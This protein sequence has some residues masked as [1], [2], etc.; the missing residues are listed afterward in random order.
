Y[1]RFSVLNLMKRFTEQRNL[2]RSAKT[3]FAT[4]F[5]TLSSLH[6]QRDN[7]KKV[8]A[9]WQLRSSKWEK[10]QL[11]KKETQ[12]VLMSSFWN[13]IVYA[14][15][16]TDLLFVHFVW[17][18]VR[19]PAMGY[20][21]EA[22][23]RAKAAIATSFQGKVDKYEEIYE[24]INIRWA[25]QL[26]G[27]LHAAGNFLNPEYYCDDC[28]I[29]Q[30]RGDV[31]HEQCIQRLATNIEKQDKITKELTVYKTDEGLCGM[32]VAIRHRKTKAPVEW[33]SYGSSNPNLQQFSIKILSLTCSSSR[34]E[35]NW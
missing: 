14:L 1:H 31:F 27:L 23:D 34:C 35:R 15:K 8:F 7:L 17:L 5:I 4:S 10:D 18:M 20:I 26:H 28:T 16:V 19:N 22:M 33:S 12:V 11:G 2:L 24:I 13:G 32:P 29:E 6:Q 21:F 9:P 3:R 30:Q 25:C